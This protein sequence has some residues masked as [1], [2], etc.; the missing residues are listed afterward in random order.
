MAHFS[1]H[2]PRK[3]IDRINILRRR[4]LNLAKYEQTYLRTSEISALEWAIPLLE[5][6][7]KDKFGVDPNRDVVLY[8]HE[9]QILIN[10]LKKRDGRICY[11]C[12][13]QMTNSQ[14]TLDH[15]L[16][17]SRGGKNEIFNLRI[18]HE[19]CNVKKGNLTLRDFVD[20]VNAGSIVL[21]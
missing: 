18:T 21:E 19:I 4:M 8:R 2:S 10:E 11:L 20:K 6:Y 7:V 15:V 3:A 12:G 5:M 17:L 1:E 14:M 9:R 16:P 13:K